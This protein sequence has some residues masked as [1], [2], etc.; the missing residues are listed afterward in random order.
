MKINREKIINELSL[1][2]FGGKGWLKSEN[3]PCPKCGKSDKF[4]IN[5]S[6]KGGGVHCFKC[7]Y[8][9]NI[10]NFLK[11]INKQ[12]L[13]SFEH[14]VSFKTKIVDP[15]LEKEAIEVNNKLIKLPRG[16][17]RIFYSE[18]LNERGFQDYQYDKYCVGETNH[19]L[20]KKLHNYLIFQIFND[21]KLVGWIARSKYSKDW[22]ENNLIKF[23]KGEEEL[24]LRY[25]NSSNTDFVN[26]LGNYDDINKNTHTVILVEG[27]F[28]S[29]NVENLLKLNFQDEI[30]CCFTFGNK[31]SNNQIELLLKKPNIEN[32]IL[33]YDENTINQC[34]IYGARLSKYFNVDIAEIKDKNVDPGNMTKNYILNTLI[35][36]KN[37]LYFYNSRLNV[38]L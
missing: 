5:I 23:K 21:N 38:K 30:K 12:Y 36:K 6:N 2:S 32:I 1:T 19:F 4:G 3:I 7:D 37:F 34:K 27:L 26:I 10:L 17:N 20:E 31:V 33:M 22:H 14:D 8:S 16:F 24:Y 11:S 25:R 29:T 18:Y 9:N 15:F 28:D 13:V 35:N